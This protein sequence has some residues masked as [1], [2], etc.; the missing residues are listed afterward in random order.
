[1]ISGGTPLGMLMPNQALAS[2]PGMVSA[3]VGTH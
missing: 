1:M 3:T 2:N